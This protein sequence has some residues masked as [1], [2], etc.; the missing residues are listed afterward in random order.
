VLCAVQKWCAVCLI[1]VLVFSVFFRCSNPV[2]EK[3]QKPHVFLIADT[4]V[5]IRDTFLISAHNQN[6]Q[7]IAVSFGWSLDGVSLDTHVARDSVCVL[8]F[9]VADTGRHRLVVRGFGNGLSSDPE[10]SLIA[11]LLN[12]PVIT[13]L[14][15]DTVLSAND[16]IVLS[17]VATDRNGFVTSFQWSIDSPGFTTTT[18]SPWLDTGWGTSAGPH[19]VR[20]RA[21]DDDSVFSPVESMTVTVVVTPPRVSL[22]HDTSVAVNDTFVVRAVRTDTF[23]TTVRYVWTVDQTALRDT[24]QSDSR[25][26]MFGRLMTGQHV[27]RVRAIDSHRLVSNADSM[28]V[29]VHGFA[30]TVSIVHDT[31]VAINDTM[32]LYAAGFD[33]NGVIKR[34]L[35]ALDGKNYRDTTTAGVLVTVWRRSA[36][37]T[38]VVRVKVIDDDTLESNVDSVRISVLLKPPPT[39]TIAGDTSVFIKAGLV[40]RARAAMS[41]SKSPITAYLW[42][43]DGRGFVDTTR[44]DSITLRY[45]TPDTGVH[46]VIV[47][48]VDRDTMVSV[49][50]TVVVHVKSGAPVVKAMTDTAVY[51]ND[52]VRV[53][54]AGFDT[55]GVIRRYLWALDGTNF[56]DTMATGVLAAVWH[57]GAVGTVVVR[58]KAVDDDTLESNVDSVRI[59]VLLK[60]LPAVTITPDT[61]VFIH[62][63]LVLHAQGAMS[64]STS[65]LAVYVWDTHQKGKSDTTS[66]DSITLRYATPDTGVNL[67]I[68]KVVDRDTMVS[69]PD[70]VVVHVKSGVPVVE[71][72]KDTAVYINDT[73]RVHAVAGDTN[74]TIASFVWSRDGAGFTDTTTTGVLRTVW[75]RADTGV[76][77]IRVAA[78][79]NDTLMSRPDSVRV[80]VR[81]GMPVVVAQNDTAVFWGDTVRAHVSGRDTNG[82]II[83]YYWHNNVGDTQWTDTTS[84]PTLPISRDY[85]CVLP[86]IVG[87]TDDDGLIGLDTFVITF[88]ARACSVTVSLPHSG[89]TVAV[90]SWRLP[91]SRVNCAFSALRT[92]MKPDT[93]AFSVYAGTSRSSLEWVYTGTDTVGT[94]GMLDTGKNYWKVVAVDN[95]NDTAVSAVDSL[96][97][98]LQRRICFIGHSII[99]GTGGAPDSGGF[100]RMVID[101]LRS[102]EAAQK[103]LGCIGTLQTGLLKPAQDDSCLAVV[104]SIAFAIWDSLVLSEVGAD[105]WVYMIG[106]NE[107]YNDVGRFYTK[108]TLIYMHNKNPRGEIYVLNGLPFPHDT[109]QGTIT[110]DSTVRSS[111]YAYNRYLDSVITAYRQVWQGGVWLVNA[112]APMALADSTRNPAYFYDLLHPNQKGYGVLGT[113]ILKTIRTNSSLY[114]K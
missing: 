60:P 20:V 103:K 8:V 96:Y 80:T 73:V 63:D 102:T 92:D 3:P 57:R 44:G 16:S 105:V 15:R 109:I 52:T 81:L 107:G 95:H 31:A 83:A 54:A 59:S 30:P 38:V 25:P 64:S 86:V 19:V 67:V 11:V 76:H 2:K 4:T 49:P 82:S 79:D 33:T 78:L 24:T 26:F 21:M 41:A 39:V 88:K 18:D 37:G 10:T 77:V 74:G 23:T 32:L 75:T 34:Y 100:R 27:I 90:N 51:I 7:T 97:G 56:R 61:S 58:V 5:S 6:S 106:V 71:A 28:T 87:V 101:S 36:V 89:D 42:D 14:T 84:L 98:V 48:V 43:K 22:S 104:G 111:L 17:A 110:I 9:G 46:L 93:F 72:M 12:P 53:H 112:F 40:L 68:V 1:A 65:P 94:V 70:T 47:K 13:S 62:A 91:K 108:E 113:E 114:K 29:H 50:D 99:A 85:H 35:W 45:T 55:N 66:G 69:V